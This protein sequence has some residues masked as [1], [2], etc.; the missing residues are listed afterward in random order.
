MDDSDTDIDDVLSSDDDSNTWTVC[1][2]LLAV[3]GHLQLLRMPSNRTFSGQDYVDDVLNCGN[4]IR[5]HTQL[6]M[7]LATFYL[8]R[9]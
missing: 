1:A 6:R 5:I 3:P 2:L 8:L 7:K 9:D 4:N